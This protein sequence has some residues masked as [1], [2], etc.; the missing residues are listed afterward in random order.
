MV[1]WGYYA[2]AV[3]IV[4]LA[5]PALAQPCPGCTLGLFAD[6]AMT[7]TTALIAGTAMDLYVAR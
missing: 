6:E 2:L 7:T 3:G 5:P 1:P 4:A